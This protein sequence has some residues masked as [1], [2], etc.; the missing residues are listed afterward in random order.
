MVSVIHVFKGQISGPYELDSREAH[1]ITAFLFHT[2]GNDDPARLASNKEKSFQGSV[3]V[4]MGFTFDDTDKDGVANPISLMREVIA[5]NPRN[6]QRI[7]PYI[8]GEEVNESPT[9]THHRFVIGFG[10]MAEKEARQWPDLMKIVEEKVKPERLRKD[11]SWSKDKARRASTWWQFARTAQDLRVAIRDMDQVFVVPRTSKHLAFCKMPSR[12]VFSENLVVFAAHRFAFFSVVQSQCHGIW[13]R[14][15]SSTLEDRQGYRPTDCFETF[16]FPDDFETDARL[17]SAGK[18]YY[19]YRAAL[20]VRHNEGL[21]KT[22]NRFHDPSEKAPDIEKLRELHAAMDRAV[23]DAYGWTD[24]RPRCEFLLDYEEDE[25]ADTPPAHAG[26]SPR[27]KKKPWRYRWPDDLRDEV[28]ARLLE[29][30]RQRS[31]TAEPETP[32]PKKVRKKK[33]E[34]P[35][36]PGMGE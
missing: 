3:V 2:G 12:T 25:D 36:L 23:L 17:E 4:G 16:P 27:R 26:G 6:A 9:H 5:K 33:G 14:F 13:V 21:T 7:F 1:L 35:T 22:Y 31:G 29:L 18:E 28:L 20:M 10:E 32:K 15:T 11:G 19:E 8:G 30:N 34:E 24:L